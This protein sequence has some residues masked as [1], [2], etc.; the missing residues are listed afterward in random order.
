[1]NILVLGATGQIGYAATNALARTGHQVSV[2]ARSGSRLRF[3]DNVTVIARPQ[4][5]AE[6]FK[7]ALQGADHAIYCVGLPEQFLFDT[8]VFEDVHCDLLE[9]FLEALAG[10]SVRR[11]TYLSSY[12]VFDVIDGVI[13]ETHPIADTRHMTPYSRSKVHAHRLVTDFA[14]SHALHLTTIHP[15]AVYG[16]LN[17]SRGMTD[18]MTNLA[19]WKWY[20]LPSINAGYFP[21]IHVDSLSEVIVKSLDKPGAYIASDQMTTLLGIAE[22]MRRQARS[23]VPLVIPTGLANL[24][25]S[26]MEAMAKVA[27]VKPLI[28]SGQMHFLT[29]GWRPDPANAIDTLGWTSMTLDEGIRRFLLKSAPEARRAESTA[30]RLEAA[31]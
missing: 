2:L 17:T 15:A 9:T 28:S 22:A 11:L 30:A 14:R 20:R 26:L 21:I 10:S 3:P 18:Y 7:V 19:T 6:A 29:R 24:S 13:K 4:L 1:M 16:G 31:E 25:V 8:S 23:Y 5:T 27:R 12:E